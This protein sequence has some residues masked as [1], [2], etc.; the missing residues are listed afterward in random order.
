MKVLGLSCGRPMGNSEVLVRAALAGAQ[1]VT[2]AEAEVIRL[3]DLFIKP[4]DGCESCTLRGIKEAIKAGSALNRTGPCHITLKNEDDIPFLAGKIRETDA[5]IMGAPAY[6]ET[7]PGFLLMIRDRV[8]RHLGEPRPKVG[9]LIGVGGFERVRFVLPMMYLCMP[10]HF[11]M[12][13]Q[14]VVKYVPRPAM[15]VLNE[16]TMAR[17][18]KLGHNVGQAMKLP[19]NEVKY[20]GEPGSCPVCHQNL[21]MV[22][23][24]FV[25]CPVCDMRGS[26]AVEGGKIK[27][28]FTEEDRERAQGGPDWRRRH[29]ESVREGFRIYDEKKAEIRK[30]LEKLDMRKAATKPPPNRS[31]VTVS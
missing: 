30:R 31:E 4:C 16:G 10:R 11:K 8:N 1:E 19:P 2:G 22:Y 14:M 21:L 3:Y 17:A 12:V 27:V 15:V 9:A 28:I 23:E 6:S 20:V 25:E 29:S 7:P 13:D 5:L 18:R 24:D 26:I